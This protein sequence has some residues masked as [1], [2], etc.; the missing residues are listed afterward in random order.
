M[1][2]IKTC[3]KCKESKPLLDFYVDKQKKD[4]I[5]SHCKLCNKKSKKTYYL[6]NVKKINLKHKKY[7]LNKSEEIKTYIK[8]YYSEN[9]KRL[10]KLA[11][12][13]YDQNPT[14]YFFTRK[15]WNAKNRSKLN[16]RDAKRRAM[17]LNATP[18]WFEKEKVALVYKK[19]KEWG[20]EVDHVIPLQGKNVCGLHCWSN[21]QLL[22]KSLNRS[23]SNR[24]Y[25]NG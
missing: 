9:S 5:S 24:E 7:N 6:K 19:A 23:K 18:V 22:N 2:D 20:F 12:I 8:N 13:K 15:N 25:P 1:S 4:G 17:E 14:K 10:K 11:K 21:L 3:S 16:A